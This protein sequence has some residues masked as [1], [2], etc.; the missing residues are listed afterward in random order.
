MQKLP[1]RG[2]TS[3]PV[4]PLDRVVLIVVWS[5]SISMGSV[6]KDGR[7]V[8]FMGDTYRDYQARVPGYPGVGFGPLGRVRPPLMLRRD[9]VDSARQ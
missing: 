7:L 5:T 6:L 3:T 9:A 4:V 8:Y 1:A 2:R